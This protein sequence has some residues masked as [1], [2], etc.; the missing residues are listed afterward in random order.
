MPAMK[1][2]SSETD[3]AWKQGVEQSQ[4]QVDVLLAKLMEVKACIQGSEGDT[5]KELDVL[6]RRVKTTAALLTYLVMRNFSDAM[7]PPFC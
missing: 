4:D 1:P 2:Q 5:K 7:E 6:W 3:A